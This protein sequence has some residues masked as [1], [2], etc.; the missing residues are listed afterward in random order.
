MH[1]VFI[2]SLFLQWLYHD[3]FCPRCLL[4][5]RMGIAPG[6]RANFRAVA[7]I[8][9]KLQYGSR[10]MNIPPDGV[11]RLNRFLLRRTNHTGSDVRVVSGQVMNPKTFPRQSVASDGGIGNLLSKFGGS[12]VNI[13]TVWNWRLFYF[14][15]NT[16]FRTCMCM[17]QKYFMSPI[18][19]YAWV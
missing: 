4:A 19:M 1:S 15:L 16:V 6:F 17:R 18:R 2:P 10:F 11:E 7:P 3:A 14:R 13:S 8:S 5:G 12:K 9:R